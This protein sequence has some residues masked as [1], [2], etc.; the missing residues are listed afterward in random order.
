LWNF[1]AGMNNPLTQ[2]PIHSVTSPIHSAP[3]SH[4][5]QFLTSDAIPSAS[6]QLLQQLQAIGL[7]Q[8][9]ILHG[10]NLFYATNE[11]HQF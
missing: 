3:A 11:L 6:L 2:S 9:Q 4:S 1:A 7:Q 8:Q 5:T 10:N